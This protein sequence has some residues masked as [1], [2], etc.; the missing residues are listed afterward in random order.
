[1]DLDTLLKNFR[2]N[3]VQLPAVHRDTGRVIKNKY[4]EE[5]D[6]VIIL[7]NSRGADRGGDLWRRAQ[8]GKVY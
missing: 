3:R 2:R 5:K 8:L 1:M 4:R 7:N 6:G